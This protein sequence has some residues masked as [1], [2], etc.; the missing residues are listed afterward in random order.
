[1]NILDILY[2]KSTLTLPISYISL[3]QF[4][5][6]EIDDFAHEIAGLSLY[7]ANHQM[8]LEYDA[9]LGKMP[10]LLPLKSSGNIVCANAT[11]KEW[12]EVC[13]RDIEYETYLLGNPPYE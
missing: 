3:S 4:Y 9:R 13:P 11:R 1:M 6:I 8:N 5:G 7:I 2:P 10:P 12:E